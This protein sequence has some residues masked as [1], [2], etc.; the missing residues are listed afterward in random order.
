MGC[1]SSKNSANVEGQ[2][3]RT[4][5]SCLPHNEERPARQQDSKQQTTAALPAS[6]K[7]ES[8][9]ISTLERKETQKNENQKDTETVKTG[10]ESNLK[11]PK[12]QVVFVLG[13]PGA[14][15]G[16]QCANIVREYGWVHLSAG[17]LL[18]AERETGSENAAMIN[19]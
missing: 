11:T 14:G 9:N 10:E 16:T 2:E 4:P 15:K 6:T 5:Q 17:D 8:E 18:R 12:P 13:G 7:S 19:R 3:N 1:G